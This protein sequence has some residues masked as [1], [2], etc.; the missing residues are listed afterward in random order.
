MKKLILFSFISISLLSNIFASSGNSISTQEGLFSNPVKT[1]Y[2]VIAT[3]EFQS[4]LYLIHD[5]KIDEL[6]T[7]PGCGR[8]FTL[9]K[10]G[11]KIGFKLIDPTTGLQTPAIYDLEKKEVTK[12]SDAAAEAGQVSFAEDGT[13]AFS[14]GSELFVEKG[15][16]VRKYDLGVYSNRTPI[17]PD[18]KEIVFKDESD[19]LWIFSLEDNSRLRIS[20]PKSGYGNAI[21]SPNGKFIAYTTT[22]TQIFVYDLVQNCNYS[23]GEGENPSW[24][25]DSQ[26]L[27]FHRRQ[28]DF[29]EVKLINSDIYLSNYNGTKVV[30]LTNTPNVIEMDAKFSDN[31]KNI[32]FQTQASREIKSLNV[33]NSLMAPNSVQPALLFKSEEPLSVKTFQMHKNT[34]EKIKTAGSYKWVHV[35]Q[36]WDTEDSGAW[37]SSYEGYRACGATTAIE[38]LASYGIIPPWPFT[39]YGHTSDYGQYVSKAYTMNGYTFENYSTWP[40]GAHGYMWNDGGSPYSNIIGFLHLNRITNT[41]R[42]D[43]PSWTDVETELNSGFPYII[44]STGLTDGH[45]V[46]VI[47]HYGTGH[48]V[49]VNDPY[50]NKNLGRYGEINNGENAIYDWS[51][52]NTG[53]VQITPAA[54]GVS[55]RIDSSAIPSVTSTATADSLTPNSSISL[56]FS[57]VMDRAATLKAITITPSISGTFT[58]TN[59]AQTLTFKPDSPFPT[60]V[61]YAIKIDTSAKSVWNKHLPQAYTL[62]VNINHRSKLSISKLYPAKDQQNVSTTVQMYILFDGNVLS[63]ANYVKFTDS[64]GKSIAPGKLKLTQLGN[65]TLFSFEPL[66]R[67]NYNS[68]YRLTLLGGFTDTNGYLLKDTIVV[69]FRT[70][71]QP[72]AEGTIVDDFETEGH[73]KNP[74]YSGTSAGIDTVS[75]KFSIFTEKKIGGLSCGRI[76]YS[77]TENEGGLCRVY[78]DL[79]PQI[80]SDDK[81]TF[82]MWVF[83][84]YSFNTL[85]YWFYDGQNQNQTVVVDT[86]NWTGWKYKEIPVSKIGG[87]GIRRFHSLLLRQAPGGNQAGSLY[88]DNMQVRSVTSVEDGPLSQRPAKYSLSQNYPNPFNPTTK[89]SYSI[90]EAGQVKLIIRDILGKEVKSL[91]NEAKPAGTYT[92]QFDAS[93]LPSGVYIYTIQVGQFRES[94]KLMLLK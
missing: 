43:A 75:S 8:Y 66:R 42:K 14:I 13:I 26:S 28:I 30:N 48:T 90:P 4:A 84:D 7:A 57:Q 64:L 70:E 10:E 78:N 61:S 58:W 31:S 65:K 68:L 35:H 83:G 86:L 62:N 27:V 49:V 41:I 21:W 85:E 51:D 44:C 5:N 67:L 38:L 88:F 53:R 17:S 56:D 63:Y 91:V 89:I 72:P 52:G 2:G 92:V 80:P 55:A 6:I 25:E 11:N 93:S 19:Q 87:S 39:T 60:G 34:T 82:G 22:G 29:N 24:S 73:W 18:A 9:N 76:C 3:N 79:T 33:E 40:T 81:A 1:S 37:G 71:A 69:N 15:S 16:E 45:I 46:L 59:Y 50:G 20:E 47:G 36:V 74:S 32:L 12:L 94:K 54:W 23:I 77:F